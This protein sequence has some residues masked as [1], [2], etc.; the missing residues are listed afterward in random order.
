MKHYIKSSLKYLR[1]YYLYDYLKKKRFYI[2]RFHFPFL[3]TVF[4][5]STVTKKNVKKLKIKLALRLIKSVKKNLDY[6]VDGMWGSIINDYHQDIIQ[7]INEKDI[8]RILY[9]L[10]NPK[11]NNL[12][13]G[14]DNLAKDIQS[15]FRIETI[16]EEKLTAD[17]FIA[18]AEYTDVINYIYHESLNSPKK[19]KINI[20]ILIDSIIKKKFNKQFFFPNCFIGEKGILTNYG[21]ASLRV[22][23]SIYQALNV[24]K[25]G[26]NICEIGPGLGRTAFF[27]NKLGAMK[28]TL[29][30]LPIPSLCQGYFL[31][32]SCPGEKF[33]FDNEKKSF[34]KGFRFLNPQTFLKNNEKYD[35]ILNV[36]SLTEMSEKMANIYLKNFINKTKWFL[37]I[38]HESNSFTV[39]NL[40]KKIPEYKLISKSRSWIR[41]GYKEEL[42]KLI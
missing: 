34:E 29:V 5:S 31:L 28:Y 35:I 7:F 1:L 26:N 12:L 19:K 13:Y 41:K 20:N 4:K 23:T 6:S 37:S 42:Y 15:P 27:A 40:I 21:I 3:N 16:T 25:Y 39:N 38:N 30:D 17:Y 9:N 2:F 33:I 24:I 11:Q 10:E 32:S 22:P 18:L 8:S 36:D 14:F